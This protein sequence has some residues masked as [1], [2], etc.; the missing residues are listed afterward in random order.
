MPLMKAL[1]LDKDWTPV[2]ISFNSVVF[3]Q[4]TPENK[5]VIAEAKRSVKKEYFGES[6]IY[7]LDRQIEA[8]PGLARLHIAKGDI[9]MFLEQVKNARAE[10]ETAVNISP[11]NTTANK[12]LWEIKAGGGKFSPAP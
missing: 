9:Y 10:Y 2:F 6:M 8:D 7:M 11:F 12:K 1:L 3:V 4:N 5:Q